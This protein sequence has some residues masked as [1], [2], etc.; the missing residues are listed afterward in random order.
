VLLAIHLAAA[1][2]PCATVTVAD[3]EP[4][5]EAISSDPTH[6]CP[7]HTRAHGASARFDEH[8]PC[9]CEEGVPLGGANSRTGPALLL[10]ELVVPCAGELD[11]ANA[12]PFHPA[13][14]ELAPPDHV[15]LPIA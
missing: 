10:A 4:L 1:S 8:C 11:F 13:R 9:G 3:H 7:E 5:P 2:V 6:P 15:P 14:I 12:V